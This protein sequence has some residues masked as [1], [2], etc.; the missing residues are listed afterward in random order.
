MV[1]CMFIIFFTDEFFHKNVWRPR[2]WER[3]G[4]ASEWLR[5]IYTL[6]VV[7]IGVITEQT[8]IT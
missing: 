2:D 6:E 3:L 7:K 5:E 4:K 1:G 8:E